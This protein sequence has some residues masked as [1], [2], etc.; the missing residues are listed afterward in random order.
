MRRRSVVLLGCL[1]LVAGAVVGVLVRP[2]PRP[3]LARPAAV[4]K[5]LRALDAHDRKPDRDALARAVE[6]VGDRAALDPP[7]RAEVELVELAASGD[8]AALLRFAFGG[9]R[10]PAR[11]RAL[12]RL[13]TAG[14]DDVRARAADRFL[15]EYPASWAAARLRSPR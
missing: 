12:L 9:P 2:A 11:A 13:A 5:A 6:A 8:D 15:A 7:S 14:A 4:E 1:G 3:G 10:S